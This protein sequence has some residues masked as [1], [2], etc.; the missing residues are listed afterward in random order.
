MCTFEV[1]KKIMNKINIAL[2]IVIVLLIASIAV[3]YSKLSQE[4]PPN[5]DYYLHQIDSLSHQIDTVE[6]EETKTVIRYKTKT[7]NEI[8]YINTSNDT[9][10]LAIRA[11]IRSEVDRSITE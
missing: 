9:Q 1:K 7:I 2:G 10:Q 3:M 5:Y 11:G 8:I 6:I 4:E